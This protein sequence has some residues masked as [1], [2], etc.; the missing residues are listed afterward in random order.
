MATTATTIRPAPDQTTTHRRGVA[1]AVAAALLVGGGVAA[2]AVNDAHTVPV[3]RH[4]GATVAPSDVEGRALPSGVSSREYSALL[5]GR[6]ALPST[7]VGRV[8]SRVLRVRGPRGSPEHTEPTRDDPLV[9]RGIA[10]RAVDTRRGRGSFAGLK[11]GREE[12]PA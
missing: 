11:F 5:A 3:P 12:H 10:D 7:S 1:L 8:E 6:D 9:W 2:A 4:V